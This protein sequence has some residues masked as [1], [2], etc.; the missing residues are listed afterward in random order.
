[1]DSEGLDPKTI[2][3]LWGIISLMWAAALSQKYVD[4]ALPKP[5]LPRKL[6]KIT[7]ILYGGKPEWVGIWQLNCNQRRK[8][9][10]DKIGSPYESISSLVAGGGFEPPTFG[11]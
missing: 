9:P 1:M 8:A 3:N 4:S 6:K 2:R 10:D 11:L 7:Q 5:K